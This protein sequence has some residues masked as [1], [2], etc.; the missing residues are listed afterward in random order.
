MLKAVTR[1]PS[2]LLLF[3]LIS[4]QVL[5]QVEDSSTGK[6][7]EPN[8][9]AVPNSTQDEVERLDDGSLEEE[10]GDSAA[11]L[12]RI[13]EARAYYSQ[14]PI[15]LNSASRESFSALN[16]L[17][18]AQVNAIL[19]H[20]ATS[21]DFIS[22]LELQSVR[23]LSIDEVRNL[24]QYVTVK[25]G[26]SNA[27][28]T[29]RARIK[30]ATGFLA[31]RTAYQTT[32]QNTDNWLG[33]RLPVYIRARWSAG[34]Q[35]SAGIV[36]ENDAGEPYGGP[37]NKLFFDYINMHLYADELPGVVRTVA[38]GDYGVNWGQGLVTYTGFGTGK[39]AFVMDVQRNPRWII[40]HASVREVGFYRGAAVAAELGS[41]KVMGMASHKRLD[42]AIDTLSGEDIDFEFSSFRL[43]GLHRTANEIAGRRS[44]TAT[45]VGGAIKWDQKWG[46]ISLQHMQHQFDVPF[47]EGGA[48]YQN[49]NVSGDQLRNTSLAWQTF[50]GPV[51]WFGEAAVDINNETALLS[52]IQIGL[53]RK[54]D[55]SIVYRRYDVGYRTLYNNV[56]GTSRRP[57]NEEGIYFGIRT[58]LAKRWMLQG[59]ADLYVHPFARFRSSRPTA[60]QDG[61]IRVTY[62]KRRKYNVYVQLRHRDNERDLS[63][64]ESGTLRT[65]DPF[66]RTSARI[67]GQV[68][69]SK[70]VTLRARVE[71]ART[72]SEGEISEGTVVYQDLILKP[73]K[74]PV[75]LT[76]RVALIDTDDYESRIYA[77]ENDLLYRFRIPAY[78]GTGYRGYVNLRWRASRKL[79]A[80][81][82]GAL[83]RREGADDQVELAAQMRYKF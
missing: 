77:Y 22:P 72:S 44:N 70:V 41:F 65:I 48:L 54:T 49:F 32:T 64:S 61:L 15:D 50:L 67:Q 5:A 28:K 83:G 2:F 82:R 66:V 78:Y 1:I 29:I 30:D 34:R 33:P 81:L 71:F 24:M 16:L 10:D 14:H 45:T 68:Q 43:S 80:E 62:E 52:G 76:A 35:F 63:R 58:Q 20:R 21:G 13:S 8:V 40:P 4:T 12:E 7:P 47:V 75:S 59:F 73:A 18:P 26:V 38:L 56:F 60:N 3:L 74:F 37:D 69:M 53:D 57:E 11:D 36:V 79:T 27:V 55:M 9:D 46:N 31:T 51:S 19:E 23:L 42:G 39:G 6:A 25:E 17:S